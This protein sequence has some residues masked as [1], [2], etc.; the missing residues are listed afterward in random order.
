MTSRLSL[1]V[2]LGVVLGAQAMA[3]T[4]IVNETF[5]G[6]AD[7]AAFQAAWTPTIGNGTALANPADVNSGILTTDTIAFPGL[8]GKGVDHIGATASTPGMVNQ[9]GGVVN[10]LNGENEAFNIAPS[11]TESVYLSA[12]IFNSGAANQRMT[13]G[14]RNI[15][16]ITGSVVTGNI[17]ELGMYNTN[18]ADPT[19][20]GVHNPPEASGA[21]E[22]GFYTGTS[23]AYRLINFQG[24]VTA[25]LQ[26][27]PSWQYP[28]L[29]AELEG[30]D[31][32]A[33]VTPFDIGAGWHRWTATISPTS[34]TITIDLFRDGMRNTSVTPDENGDRPG[35]P[36]VDATVT[37]NISAQPQGFNALRFG[38]PSGLSS[39]GSAI[40]N[41]NAFDNIVL[42]LIDAVVPPPNN[43]DFNNDQIVDG[44][45]LLIWQ[46]GLGISDGTALKG[47]GDATGDGNVNAAD[48]V[49]WQQT[50]GG[51]PAVIAGA[52]IPEPVALLIAITGFGAIILGKQ[53][54]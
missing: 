29:P 14:L 15:D 46:R 3:E 20:P 37:W 30:P 4:V 53:R 22:P 5:D 36:G 11:A 8:Q 13:V 48:L 45:D 38:G 6:Y 50:F 25:P 47:N 23:Y 17:V 28:Q 7:D 24:P 35:T 34:V 33:L 39:A 2:V 42:K 41:S 54:K 21:A 1:A 52:P 51:P 16:N 27:Q 10:Q 44:A 32:N 19:V 12:D 49:K 43:A 18:S 26:V 31:T 40:P 9:W